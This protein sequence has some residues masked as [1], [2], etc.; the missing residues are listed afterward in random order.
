M[1]WSI[2]L[3]VFAVWSIFQQIL[4]VWSIFLQPGTNFSTMSP[5]NRED[6]GMNFVR[7]LGFGM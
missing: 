3:L 4:L 1:S 2:F 6:A 5:S 7:L